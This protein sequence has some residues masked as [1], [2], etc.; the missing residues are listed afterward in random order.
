MLPFC[1]V[2]PTAFQ[3]LGAP[4]EALTV[5]ALDPRDPAW[6]VFALSAG[7]AGATMTS[8]AFHVQTW[9]GDSW[10]RAPSAVLGLSAK[11]AD[12]RRVPC[13]CAGKGSSLHQWQ[14]HTSHAILPS[15]RRRLPR[16]LMGL[17]EFFS[18]R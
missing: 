14:P 10:T 1:S 15:S 3:A 5:S 13:S 12:F 11:V 9:S 18:S 8:L 7:W 16:L 2:L 6:V 4:P 17:R